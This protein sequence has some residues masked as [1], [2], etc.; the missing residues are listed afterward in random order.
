MKQ[1]RLVNQHGTLAMEDL[2][3]NID[4]SAV[5]GT[6]TLRY[7][8]TT[9]GGGVPA[10][11]T[12]GLFALAGALGWVSLISVGRRAHPRRSRTQRVEWRGDARSHTR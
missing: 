9:Q 4:G 1:G 10:S 5:I 3:W 6:V 8:Y 11:S 2:A 7:T 12:I